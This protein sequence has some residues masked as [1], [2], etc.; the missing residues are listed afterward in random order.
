MSWCSNNIHPFLLEAKS[1]MAAASCA[2]GQGSA[3]VTLSQA[4]STL[5]TPTP[6]L[7]TVQVG[8]HS[9][10]AVTLH[11]ISSHR[12]SAACSILLGLAVLGC[13]PQPMD[14]GKGRLPKNPS[15]RMGLGMCQASEC[16]TQSVQAS[17]GHFSQKS[18]PDHGGSPKQGRQTDPGTSKGQSE[19]LTCL[20]TPKR[21]VTHPS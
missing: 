4:R 15:T 1:T 17:P 21:G 14:L 3:L 7:F 19:R 6:S 20:Q 12:T 2:R 16:C 11:P 8:Q 5:G 9:S 18:C 13:A 10:P